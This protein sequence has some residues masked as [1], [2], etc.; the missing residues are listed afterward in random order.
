MEII[1]HRIN[2]MNDLQELPNTF[3][4]EIDIRYHKNELILE[5]DPFNHHEKSFVSLRSFLDSYHKKATLILN[6]K[7]EGVEEECIKLMNEFGIKKWFFLDVSMPYFVKYTNLVGSID[8]NKFSKSNFAVRY[9]EY[10]P[11]EYAISFSGKCEWVWVDYFS[12]SALDKNTYLSLKKLNF[13]ICLVSPEL[14]GHQLSK[15][16]QY[17]KSLSEFEIDAVCTK[18]PEL[19]CHSE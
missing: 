6:I 1:K 12:K 9:S 14:Q 18:H 2:K 10:E 7:T 5:H 8:N 15:I 11:I 13:K 17:K 16:Q 4:A 3:G 19:W